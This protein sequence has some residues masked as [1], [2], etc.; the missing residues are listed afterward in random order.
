MLNPAR[1][2]P[3]RPILLRRPSG[4]VKQG[5]VAEATARCQI[6]RELSTAVTLAAEPNRRDCTRRVLFALVGLGRGTSEA[7][8]M[9]AASAGLRSQH[10]KLSSGVLKF[11]G[12]TE[13]RQAL[14]RKQ[15]RAIGRART[16]YANAAKRA[17][18]ACRGLP[19]IIANGGLVQ[20]HELIDDLVQSLAYAWLKPVSHVKYR[21]MMRQLVEYAVSRELDPASMTYGLVG[22][23]CVAY[24][25]V[26]NK[27]S[28]LYSYLSAFVH[29]ARELEW[30]FSD[31]AETK[32]RGLIKALI[33][34]ADP[35]TS[36]YAYPWLLEHTAR[37]GIAAQRDDGSFALADARM[38]AA[39]ELSR[40]SGMRASTRFQSARE[41]RRGVFPLSKG[42][43]TWHGAGAGRFLVIH[44]PP[45]K[46]GAA[47]QVCVGHAADQPFS[48]YAIL[49][50]WY[51][52]SGMENQ[53]DSAPFIPG[54]CDG[55][56]RW[57]SELS[58]EK[59]VTQMRRIARK[60]GV[61]ESYVSRLRGHSLRAGCATDM[62]SR[63]VPL[64]QAMVVGGWRS[65]AILMYGR[66]TADTMARW[67]AVI[68][69]TH[70][71]L[72]S[73]Y[74]GRLGSIVAEHARACLIT[75]PAMPTPA[76]ETLVAPFVARARG[77]Y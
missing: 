50:R 22:G 64:W 16:Q 42:A 59:F 18:P 29:V 13:E 19:G 3:R 11:P 14:S 27:P 58:R 48:T 20:H 61:P 68:D 21:T 41:K 70:A 12:L 76:S 74:L 30:A 66:I 63:G 47:R 10:A 77:A 49:R 55:K 73:A 32:V 62:L 39:L 4:D 9:K 43:V 34:Q 5:Q 25:L 45:G 1:R 75:P 44:V 52:V 8:A 69:P 56:L 46:S 67:T 35:K 2:V 17:T 37:Y 26:G 28:N 33:A 71:V 15:Q 53:A 65:D 23:F 24:V 60:L 7:G 38:L 54:I 72:P 57:S 6:S 51:E 40:S 31:F 36:N